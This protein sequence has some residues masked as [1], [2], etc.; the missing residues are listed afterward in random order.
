MKERDEILKEAQKLINGDRAEDYGDAYT[1]HKRIAD[2]WTVILS[3]EIKPEDVVLCMI[4]MKIA[5]LV[6]Q[7]KADSIVDICGYAALL[8]E[9]SKQSENKS[10]VPLFE[11]TK[12]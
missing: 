12:E 3:K 4:A 8:G 7:K 2:L 5:R 11:V 6:H 9:F 1:N 10:E